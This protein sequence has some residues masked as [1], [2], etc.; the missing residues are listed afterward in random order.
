MIEQPNSTRWKA[1]SAMPW[2]GGN[3][4]CI[5]SRKSQHG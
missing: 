1:V 3:L 5:T 4:F 2:R